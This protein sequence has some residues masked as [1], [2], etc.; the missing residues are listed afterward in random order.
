MLNIQVFSLQTKEEIEEANLKD[1]ETSSNDSKSS[2]RE[3]TKSSLNANT[4]SLEKTEEVTS[5]TKHRISGGIQALMSKLNLVKTDNSHKDNM[6][7]PLDI[8]MYCNSNTGKGCADP[9]AFVQI[10]KGHAIYL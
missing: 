4:D 8:D 10:K 2:S 6:L 7:S 3:N 9:N 1:Q 5:P